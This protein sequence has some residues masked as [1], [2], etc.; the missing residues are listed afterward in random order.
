MN[1]TTKRFGRT[2]R[3]WLAGGLIL[4]AAAV[5]FSYYGQPAPVQPDSQWLPVQPRALENHLGL[6]G[7]IEPAS[8]HTIA[9]PFEGVL[10]DVAIAEGERA[11]R[12][13]RLLTIDTTQLDIQL[14]EALAAKLKAQRT[15]QDMENWS[16]SDEVARARRA[17]T[18]ARLNLNDTEA[19]LADTRGL[20]ERGIVARMEVD[21]LEQQFKM[22]Q[23]DLVAS[24]NELRAAL[25]RG[26]GES[27][28]IAGMELANAQARYRALQE[29]RAQHELHAPFT[30]IVLRPQ[31]AEGSGNAPPV[32]AG[33]RVT[34]GMPLYELASLEQIQA[35]SRVEE[36][37]LHQLSEGMPVQITG[38]GFDGFILGGRIATIGVQGI[39]SDV[40]GGTT[41]E[42]TV[43]IDPLSPEQRQRVRLG[44]SARLAIVTY[45][46]E[47]GLAVPAEALRRSDDGRTFV[48]YRA[49]MNGAP[50]RVAVTTGR[51][52]PH[53]VEVFGMEPGYVELSARGVESAGPL[54]GTLGSLGPPGGIDRY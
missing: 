28:Q 46:A 3:R 6:V 14:R 5:A 40:G 51:A 26:E 16:Q 35:V 20:F 42:I 30:G 10:R 33:T 19:K 27:R 54:P 22:Q 34:P 44:M 38:D 49:D 23:L 2:R 4:I 21:T 25:A 24:Q 32:Q 52:V 11:E 50:R 7:R 39:S 29:L 1:S 53:G 12:G 37:D 41:Y 18:N 48:V 9:A 47:S 43:A 45:R 8:R 36:A 31:R 17:V 13:Q 15:V